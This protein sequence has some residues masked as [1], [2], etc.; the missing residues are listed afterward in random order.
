L[1]F[2]RNGPARAQDRATLVID[3][4]VTALGGGI[5]AMILGAFIASAMLPDECD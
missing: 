4:R 5:F 1:T 3:R 2:I